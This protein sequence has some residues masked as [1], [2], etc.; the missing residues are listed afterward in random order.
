MNDLGL[1]PE[2]PR[3]NHR[4]RWS[5][6][7][8]DI[9][10]AVEALVGGRVA[11]ARDQ[12]GGYS[13]GVAARLQLEDDRRIFVKAVNGDIN[14]KSPAF[15]RGEIPALASF[16]NVT[17]DIPVP[18]L[19]HVHD[20]GHWIALILEDVDG[21]QPGAPWTDADIVNVLRSMAALADA[22]TPSPA[23]LP[24]IA[25]RHRN[26][27]TGWRTLAATGGARLDGWSRSHIHDLAALESRWELSVAGTTLAHS[28]VRADNLIITSADRVWFVDWGSASVGAPWF[29]VVAMAASV[30]TAGGPK[31]AELMRRAGA[32]CDLPT[33]TLLPVVAAVAGY[34]TQGALQ[35]APKGMPTV[36]A[37]Q[38]SSGVVMR[39][40]VQELTGWE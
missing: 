40:W 31:P 19:L 28:D 17:A 29:D 11:A 14:P 10:A 8:S 12:R 4:T 39:E 18:R 9:V 24:T 27:F 16:S 21:R 35:P 22:L 2:R 32:W 25:E 3:P 5:D 34:F 15:Y 26:V 7:P 13:P 30:T 20:D 6:V 23:T 33:E 38:R 1:E 36:R 37:Y